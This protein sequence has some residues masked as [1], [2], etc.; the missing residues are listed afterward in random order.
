MVIIEEFQY[1]RVF[2]TL[3]LCKVFHLIFQLSAMVGLT[4]DF[5][6]DNSMYL[7]FSVIVNKFNLD[8][9][10]GIMLWKSDVEDKNEKLK[11]M[12]EDL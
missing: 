12:W 1:E 8:S 6:S 4:C 3:S 9:V 11:Y 7:D 5:D 10:L 2:P